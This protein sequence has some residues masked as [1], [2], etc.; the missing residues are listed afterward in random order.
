MEQYNEKKRIVL[1]MLGA[2]GL[3]RLFVL[4]KG[5]SYPDID[6]ALDEYKLRD[7]KLIDWWH[8]NIHIL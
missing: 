7:Y 8:E 6:G 1:R 3:E 5:L 2:D 4:P